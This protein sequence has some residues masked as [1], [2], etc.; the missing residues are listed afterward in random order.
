LDRMST[1][2]RY[3]GESRTY[4]R[5][6]PELNACFNFKHKWWMRCWPMRNT[7]VRKSFDEI[8]LEIALVGRLFQ[9][10]IRDHPT[11]QVIRSKQRVHH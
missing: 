1:M 2:A 11:I 8:E 3:A 10:R 5:V 6:W 9:S 4:V 7:V